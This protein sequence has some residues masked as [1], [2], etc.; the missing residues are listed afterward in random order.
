MDNEESRSDY[1]LLQTLKLTWL[2]A[3]FPSALVSAAT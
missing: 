2:R 1:E 3:R